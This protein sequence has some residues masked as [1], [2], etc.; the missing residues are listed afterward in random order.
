MI[1]V[2]EGAA[3]E[4]KVGAELAGKCSKLMRERIAFCHYAN[5]ISEHFTV[6]HV[7]HLGWQDLARRAFTLAGEVSRK[8]A[9]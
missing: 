7:N 6:A 1:V 3:S 8:L 2:S 5:H 9:K 4:A